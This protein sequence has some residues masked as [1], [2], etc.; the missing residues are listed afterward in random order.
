MLGSGFSDDFD[1]DHGI[2]L[3]PLIDAVF[4]LIIFFVMTAGVVRSAMNI[5]LPAASNSAAL[6]ADRKIVTLAVDSSGKIFSEGRETEAKGIKALIEAKPGYAIDLQVDKKAP[7]D[8]FVRVMD[9]LKGLGKTDV[10]VSTLDE[11]KK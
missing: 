7:F 1:D 8:T 9:E 2:D 3:T 5:D 4:M 11:R 10:N 6:K